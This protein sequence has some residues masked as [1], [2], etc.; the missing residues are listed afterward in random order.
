L[1]R[2]KTNYEKGEREEEEALE[3]HHDRHLTEICLL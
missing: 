3:S 1:G 2:T